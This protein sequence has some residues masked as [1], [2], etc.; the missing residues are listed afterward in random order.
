M[1]ISVNY[2]DE[3][4]TEILNLNTW[5]KKIWGK[6]EEI[7]NFWAR[8]LTWNYTSVAHV[9]LLC[10]DR[11]AHGPLAVCHLL[12]QI[13]PICGSEQKEDQLSLHDTVCD[14]FAIVSSICHD[15]LIDDSIIARA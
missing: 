5:R 8:K 4:F 10:Y 1:I 11:E 2:P 6:A 13:S 9:Y 3:Q 14:Y 12:V 15:N 7:S